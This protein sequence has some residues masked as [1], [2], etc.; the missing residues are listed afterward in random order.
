MLVVSYH[1]VDKLEE[2]HTYIYQILVPHHEIT[3]AISD[4]HNKKSAINQMYGTRKI[5]FSVVTQTQKDKY[6]A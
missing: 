6:N 5:I 1:E 2:T 4:L 3:S